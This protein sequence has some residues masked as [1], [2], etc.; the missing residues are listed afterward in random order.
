[1]QPDEDQIPTPNYWGILPADVRYSDVTPGAKVLY[2]EFSALT[3]KEGF[4][5]ATNQ[6]LAGLYHVESSTIQRWVK[7]LVDAGFITIS[8]VP[9]K[10]GTMRKVRLVTAVVAKTTKMPPVAKMPGGGGKNKV[11]GIDEPHGKFATHN[12]TSLITKKNKQT[13]PDTPQASP[14]FLVSGEAAT[15]TQDPQPTH[16]P[17][18]PLTGDTI[19]YPDGSVRADNHATIPAERWAAIRAGLRERIANKKPAAIVEPVTRE[20]FYAAIK[21]TLNQEGV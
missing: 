5:W 16:V 10:G 12:N 8:L 6:W 17:E 15:D 4:A 13:E 3:Q 21:G 11:R 9:S 19:M 18:E 2:V 7:E 1:M 20:P 14:A